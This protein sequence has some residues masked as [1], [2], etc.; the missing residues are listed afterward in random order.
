M[1]ILSLIDADREWI[2]SSVNF[3]AVDIPREVSL[4]AHAILSGDLFVVPDALADPRFA[5]NPLVSGAPGIRFYAAAPL[6]SSEGFVAGTLAVADVRPHEGGVPEPT[7]GDLLDL[8]AVA[9]HTLDFRRRAQIQ[10][11]DAF[12]MLDHV[13]DRSLDVICTLNERGAFLKVSAA[14]ATTLGYPPKELFSRH[15]SDFL[16]PGDRDRAKEWLESPPANSPFA[17]TRP[18]DA[19][20]HWRGRRRGRPKIA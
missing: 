11:R 7:R 4:S 13:L 10:V 12:A 2:R 6:V 15:L 18:M 3:P 5:G 14:S 8:A 17:G 20:F 9:V 19:S 16:A 1:A